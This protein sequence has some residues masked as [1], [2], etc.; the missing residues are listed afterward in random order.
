MKK[1]RS[2]EFGFAFTNGT[3]AAG[4]QTVLTRWPGMQ[5][6][7][8]VMQRTAGSRFRGAQNLNFTSNIC[9]W[10]AKVH[11]YR[12]AKLMH[13]ASL[14][15]TPASTLVSHSE[16]NV[17]SICKPQSKYI[18]FAQRYQCTLQARMSLY[19]LPPHC[20]SPLALPLVTPTIAPPI[21]PPTG[22][23]Q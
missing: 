21:T 12:C 7:R 20:P 15:A 10:K 4:E 8:S 2:N 11:W 22:P 17:L 16:T 9:C 19:C 5:S 18:S 3:A 14:A 13:F 6:S 23:A 1:L